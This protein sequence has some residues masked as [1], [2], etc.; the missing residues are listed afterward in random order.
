SRCERVHDCEQGWLARLPAWRQSLAGL[1]HETTRVQAAVTIGLLPLT[2]VLFQQV[3]L[4]SPIANAVAI[5]TVSYL[6]TPLALL[7]A[8]VCC[9]GQPM[10]PAAQLMLQTSDALFGLLAGMLNGLVQLP[11]AWVGFAAPPAWAVAVA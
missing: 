2:L 4:I 9:L 3:S 1:L 10:E 11:Y 6:V 7:G 8:M 5:P